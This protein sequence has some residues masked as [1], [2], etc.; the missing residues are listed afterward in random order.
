MVEVL[1]SKGIVSI[2]LLS[3]III[4]PKLLS[5]VSN[6]F[7]EG[8][9]VI[10]GISDRLVE[11]L[12]LID[13]K[14]IEIISLVIDF[15]NKERSYFLVQKGKLLLP[16]SSWEDGPLP[17]GLFQMVTNNM[18]VVP[19]WDFVL[20]VA[21]SEESLL[22]TDQVGSDDEMVVIRVDDLLLWIERPK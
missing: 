10:N 19:D 14:V 9:I 15:L 21:I 1:V 8:K 6:L 17:K 22:D 5:R 7:D 2:K 11:N 18:E 20:V 13:F 4:D 12:V 3:Y 16:L